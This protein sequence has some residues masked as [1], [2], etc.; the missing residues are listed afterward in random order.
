MKETK[1][2]IILNLLNL[3]QQDKLSDMRFI[4]LLVQ[5]LHDS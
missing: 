1:K 5:I 3:W 4:Y 2:E